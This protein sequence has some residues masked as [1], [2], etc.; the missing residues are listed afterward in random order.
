MKTA[1]LF[2]QV[3]ILLAVLFAVYL[4]QRLTRLLIRKALNRWIEK[5]EIYWDDIFYKSDFFLRLETI[6]HLILFYLSASWMPDLADW[7]Q[8]ISLALTA[9]MTTRA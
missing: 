8:R 1:I 9:L 7:V 3:I 2:S 5:T 6:L 4:L